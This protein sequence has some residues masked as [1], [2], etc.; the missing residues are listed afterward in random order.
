MSFWDTTMLHTMVTSENSQ[1][2]PLQEQTEDADI[3]K[4]KDTGHPTYN[5]IPGRYANRI[6]KAQFTIDGKTF[7]T[8]KNDGQNTLHSGTNNWS[9]RTW[10]VAAVSTDSITFSLVDKEGDST[11]MPGR[12]DANV[13]Y[14]VFNSTW[15]I[16]MTATASAKTRIFPFAS[17]SPFLT[18]FFPT[19]P[20]PT[21]P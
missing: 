12:V 10:T 18:P 3:S 20:S 19:L 16:K 15:S 7:R 14:S 2:T 6:S 21:C 13:T 17:L 1:R 8:Q 4:A 5:S 9:Y 11:G